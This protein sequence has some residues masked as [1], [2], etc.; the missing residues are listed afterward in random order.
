MAHSLLQPGGAPVHLPGQPLGF[1]GVRWERHLSCTVCVSSGELVSGCDPPGGCQLSSISGS[2]GSSLGACSQ[3]GG[4]C[5]LW[6]RDCPSPSG[7]GCPPPASPSSAGEGPVRSRLGLLWCSLNPLF[8][9]RAMLSRESSLSLSFIFLSG[10]P[11]VWVAI[12]R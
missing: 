9:E 12:S 6:G 10:C 11:T 1:L 8:C 7:S 5:R 2:L 3:F 4:G